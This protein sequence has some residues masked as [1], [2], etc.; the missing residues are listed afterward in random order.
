VTQALLRPP[1][2]VHLFAVG[3][4]LQILL[5]EFVNANGVTTFLMALQIAFKCVVLT[6]NIMELHAF[7]RQGLVILTIHVHRVQ[8]S[9][10][11][12]L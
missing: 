5:W 8:S 3:T 2:G 11:L 6:K 4:K 7:A 1:K 12:I 9:R 10:F